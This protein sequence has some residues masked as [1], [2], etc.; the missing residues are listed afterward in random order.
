MACQY[1]QQWMLYSSNLSIYRHLV[2]TLPLAKLYT[3]SLLSTLTSRLR[4][5]DYFEFTVVSGTQRDRRVSINF[6]LG[7]EQAMNEN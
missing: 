1:A 7:H 2:F 5:E 4:D 6:F 3:I